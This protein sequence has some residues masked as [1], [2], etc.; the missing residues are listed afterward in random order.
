MIATCLRRPGIIGK[1]LREVNLDVKK[2]FII[3][4]SLFAC[5]EA[6][7]EI[8]YINQKRDKA[9]PVMILGVYIELKYIYIPCYSIVT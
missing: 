8:P 6:S 4:V 5:N 1:S 7:Q 9:F 2:R 3:S